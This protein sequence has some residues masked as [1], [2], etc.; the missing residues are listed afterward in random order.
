M[1]TMR[2]ITRKPLAFFIIVSIFLISGPTRGCCGEL[3]LAT[4]LSGNYVFEKID[5]SSG[6]VV[7]TITNAE[8]TITS[9]A[10]GVDYGSGNLWL[11]TTL[12]G[13]YVFEKIDP[14][15][16]AVVQTI[17]NAEGTI[18]STAGGFAAGNGYLWLA[19][20]SGGNYVFEEINPSSGAVMQ[21]ITHAEGTLTSTAGG[22]AAGDGYLWLAGTSGGNYVLEKIDPSS[23]AVVQTVT[24][25]EGTIISTAGGFAVG[26][27]YLWL[28]TTLNGNYVFEQI[29]P[30]S[31]AVVQTVTH[32]E[33]TIISTAGGF[34]Y[35]EDAPVAP[36]ATAATV[37][38]SSGFTANW[39]ASSGATGYDLDVST[40]SGFG[41]YVAGYQN[42]NA[43]S[44]T[45]QTVTGLSASTTYYYR[46]RASNAV[47][48]S[49]DSGN[50]ISV[51]TSSSGTTNPPSG[52]NLVADGG[53]EN[54]TNF[55]PWW[56]VSGEVADYPRID[57]YPP[58]AH[59]GND[60]ADIG[61]SGANSIS[62]TLSTTPGANYDVSIWLANLDDP[63]AWQVTFGT[64]ILFSGNVP[65]EPYTLYET[66][67]QA[68]GA[69]TILTISYVSGTPS[70]LHVDDI[71]V[72]ETN[73]SSEPPPTTTTNLYTG[74]AAYYQFEASGLDSS[75]NHLDLTLYG[76]PGFGPGLFGE[77]LELDHDESQDGQRPVDDSVFDFGVGDFTIQV[78][79]N[80]NSFGSFEQ[81]FIEKFEGQA[82]PGWTLTSP[83][84]IQFYTSGAVIL[85]GY[86][87]VTTNVWHQVVV[88]RS[89]NAF[90]MLFDDALV[91]S[92][93]STNA[94]SATS[95]GLLIGKRNA[96]DGRNLSV[97]GRL[98]EIA[99]WNRAL[100]DTEIGSLY[101]GGQG[102]AITS[103]GTNGTTSQESSWIELPQT[104]GPPQPVP[105]MWRSSI[106]TMDE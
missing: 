44:A 66:N 54:G 71:S 16:G 13:D 77:G 96:D 26:D 38:S 39:E 70:P 22:F 85:D 8:G 75:S 78:W 60:Y 10:G 65:L 97:D 99:I 80:L 86:P 98:D 104:G 90:S 3:W 47:G 64:N 50:R 1:K 57:D 17:T 9:T 94:I 58:Y 91:A 27:G 59:T 20:T 2:N 41:S 74:L 56:S 4:T 37:V 28:A 101:N 62:Q 19:A 40:S 15:S 69:S 103:S 63:S 51:T 81:T 29:D 31:G 61:G 100:S 49:G 42:L 23:G 67:V 83:N 79:M 34:A 95:N 105:G 92:G 12:N 73:A 48:T 43:G 11:A 5:P 7:Q 82:G 102:T 52:G 30:S 76:N 14:S 87:S 93:T 55:S 106:P 25:A 36:T 33:G 6:A 21:T 89:G 32:A 53:F 35:E 24:H 68:A 46:T 72:I 18:T 88:R 45:S 84:H